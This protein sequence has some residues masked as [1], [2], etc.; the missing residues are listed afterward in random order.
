LNNFFQV[1][2]FVQKEMFQLRTNAQY[3]LTIV[4]LKSY[5]SKKKFVQSLN[6]CFLTLYFEDVVA[7]PNMLASHSLCLNETRIKN[8]NLN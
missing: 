2:H 3:K 6:T 8:V 5:Y 1:D 4:S 7:Y